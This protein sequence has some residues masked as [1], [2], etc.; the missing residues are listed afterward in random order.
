MHQ[1]LDLT[2]IAKADRVSVEVSHDNF[3]VDDSEPVEGEPVEVNGRAELVLDCD[4]YAAFV[5]PYG[6][7]DETVLLTKA[8]STS[9]RPR[10]R[11]TTFTV[12]AVD[13]SWE[14]DA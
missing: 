6:H 1:K 14:A 8:R 4:D 12:E 7:D 2:A 11:S 3:H 5:Y 10:D 13:A 9:T